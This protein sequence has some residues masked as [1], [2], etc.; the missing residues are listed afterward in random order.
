LA[1]CFIYRV[2]APDQAMLS[3]VRGHDGD[4]AVSELLH[5]GN[6]PVARATAAA[7]QAWLA[8]FALSA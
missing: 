7:V 5:G 1:A 6:R 8:P 3:L 2:L 4:W